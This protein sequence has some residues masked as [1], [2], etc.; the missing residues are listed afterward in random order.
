MRGQETT[1]TTGSAAPD[2]TAKISSSSPETQP[3]HD[4]STAA[5][6]ET[7]WLSAV[8]R[9][10][11]LNLTGV[12]I[13]LPAALDTQLERDAGLSYIEYMVLAM[14]SE[15]PHR[16]LRMS[17]LAAFINAS[18]SRLSHVANRLER[19]SFI[20]READ[21]RDGRYTNAVLTD[22]GMDK[23]VATAPGHVAAVRSF[24]VDAL[25]PDQLDGLNTATELI[26][27]RVDP[28]GRRTPR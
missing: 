12:M 2:R 7:H 28:A 27:G 17:E 21:P 20:R 25:S 1:N 15:Q 11:W 8:E 3:A 10:A 4:S 5:T 22:A 14:L 24:V 26:L 19:Q 23:V 9:T 18:L 13:K 6:D 16:M